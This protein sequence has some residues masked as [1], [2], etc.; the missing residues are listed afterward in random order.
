M[1]LKER[2]VSYKKVL[3][4]DGV[5]KKVVIDKIRSL[6]NSRSKSHKKF[7]RVDKMV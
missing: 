2:T 6:K 5:I 1:K 4:I 3:A 7:H